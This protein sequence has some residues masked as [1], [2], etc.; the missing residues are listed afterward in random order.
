MAELPPDGPAATPQ[1]EPDEAPGARVQPQPIE[2]TIQAAPGTRLHFSV[3]ALPPEADSPA[4]LIIDGVQVVAVGQPP[5]QPPP[6]TWRERA[7]AGLRRW[8]YS[9]E[10]SLFG[11]ALLVYLATRLVGLAAYPIYFFS[12]EAIQTVLAADLVR[13]N[14]S[15]YD[16]EFL[17]TYFY[18]ID[19]HKFNLSASVYLQ[20]IPYLLFGKTVFVTRAVSVLVSLLAA[21]CAGLILRDG[22]GLPY[23]WVATLLLSIAPAWFLHSRTA[24][25]TVLM[26][27][28]YTAGLYCYILYRLRAPHYLYASLALLAL[29]FYSYSAGQLVVVATGL[30]LLLSDLPYHWRNR[31]TGLRGLGLLLALMLPYLRFRWGHPAAVGDQLATLNSYWVQPL[32]LSEK[33]E[34]FGR[35]YL[36]GL[37][38][39]Y[40]FI[41]NQVDLVRHLMKDYGHLHRAMLPF[42]ALGLVLAL[43]N[44][45]SPAY[46]VVLIALVAGPLGAAL[47]QAAITRLLPLVVPLTL[48]AAVGLIAV[49]TWL[50]RRRVPRTALALVVFAGLS[51]ANLAMLT[52]ALT[53]GPT[54]FQNYGLEGMQYGGQQL[55]AAVQET[56]AQNPQAELVVT[57]SWANGTEAIARFFLPDSLPARLDSIDTYLIR[58]GVIR[59]ETIFVMTADE[60]IRAQESGKFTD[61]QALRVV[62]YPNGQ[63]GFI[64]ASLRYVD[65]IDALF[66]TEYAERRKLQE[67]QVIIDGQQAAVRYSLLDMGRIQD[68]WD[69]SPRSVARTFEAN[70]FV[71][72]LTFEQPRSLSGLDLV[73]GDTE[74]NLQLE[75]YPA[76]GGDPLKLEFGLAGSVE[77]PAASVDF[78]QTVVASGLRLVYNDLRQAEPAHVHLWELIF[79]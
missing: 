45:R 50:E 11:L 65:N 2:I 10:T 12:D 49:L 75:L 59:P 70:P 78:G 5:A 1:A 41:P 76:Q 40:W 52:D 13:D 26:V 61:L 3:E 72:E 39:G 8:P 54:W 25:E 42:T 62:P 53:D 43:K 63:P 31:A 27:S 20:V 44:F 51:L 18:N 38:P 24:F 48:L 29:A 22:L 73:I 71:I 35:E 21:A 55:F 19:R 6:D 33:L 30:L 37:S 7:A 64:F 14:F 28:F 66:M 56:L 34:R 47:V 77:T 9:L 60:Y 15:N 67:G 69:G 32:A 46:R 68:L 16:G 57:P 79:R 74:A 4:R 23:G 58:R 17:P 36:Y